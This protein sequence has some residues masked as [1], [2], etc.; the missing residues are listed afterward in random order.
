MIRQP[1][2]RFAFRRIP[3]SR[4]PSTFQWLFA[5]ALL[6]SVIFGAGPVRGGGTNYGDVTFYTDYSEWRDD[7]DG[8][9]DGNYLIPVDTFFTTRENIEKADQSGTSFTSPMPADGQ[10]L[11]GSLLTFRATN[12]GLCGSFTLRALQQPPGSCSNCGLSYDDQDPGGGNSTG[13]NESISIGDID[14]MENDDFE[15]TFPTPS[16]YAMS[17]ALKE[18]SSSEA[19]ES[20]SVYG[21]GG[22][23]L[24]SVPGSAI[25]SSGATGGFVGVI[26]KEP[27]SRVRYDENSGGDDIAIGEFY[28]A[29]AN[30]DPDNDGLSNLAELTA[31]TSLFNGDTDGDGLNDGFELGTG[32]FGEEQ[33]VWDQP[34]FNDGQLVRRNPVFSA[35]VDGDGDLDLVSA[36]TDRVAWYEN[37][38][39]PWDNNNWVEWVI[40]PG[41][42]GQDAFA[43][44]AV[45]MDGDGDMD[46]IAVPHVPNNVSKVGTQNW[47]E[48]NGTPKSVPWTKKT[49][50]SSMPFGNVGDSPFLLATDLDNDGYADLLA[51]GEKGIDVD[52]DL[53]YWYKNAGGIIGNSQQITVNASLRPMSVFAADV[54][55]DG[56]TDVFAGYSEA[57]TGD[58]RWHENDG[59]PGGAGDW[60]EHSIAD[61]QDFGAFSVA[62]L[63]GDGDMDLISA[64]DKSLKWR[65][66][67]GLGIFADSVIL[68]FDIDFTSV[69]G[70]DVDLDGDMDVV[71]AG[72]SGSAWYENGGTPT[73]FFD[74]TKHV[75]EPQ[76]EGLDA[77]I[78]VDLDGDGDLD[79]VSSA[80]AGGL[81]TCSND[82]FDYCKIVAH[83][84]I[85]L[86]NPLLANTDGIGDTDAV[87]DPDAD[88]L[89]NQ[90]EQYLG[91]N[92]LVAD[93]DGDGLLDG[94]EDSNGNGVDPGETDPLNEDTDGDGLLD[95]F[96]VK[97]GFNP[98]VGGEQTQDPD[99]DG[100]DNLEEQTAGT[101]PHDADTDGDG[102]WDGAICGID[103]PAPTC[104]ERCQFPNLDLDPLKPDSDGDGMLDG[105]EVKYRAAG[106]VFNP[107]GS[108]DQ[109]G[110]GIIDGQED[111]DSDGLSN[112]AEQAAG[113]DPTDA[114]TDGDGLTDGTELG[115]GQF[116]PQQ[117]ISDS[118]SG[119]QYVFAADM[120]GDGDMDAL[121]ASYADDKIAWYE[122]DGM[123]TGLGDWTEHVVSTNA[124][125]ATSVFAADVDG[126]GD[127][128]VLS[129]SVNDSK[130]AWY[131]NDG[132]PAVGG[133]TERIISLAAGS[134]TQTV[135]AAD[136]DGDGDMDVLSTSVNPGKVVWYENDGTPAGLGDWK[137]RSIL[138]LSNSISAFAADL[139]RD[140]KLHVLA[141]SSTGGEFIWSTN[142]G[143]PKLGPWPP[144]TLQNDPAGGY[145]SVYAV[146]VDGDGR[147]DAL[148]ALQDTNTIGW[149]RNT[150]A[151]FSPYPVF[152][153]QRQVI[154]NSSLADVRGGALVAKDLDGDGDMDVLSASFSN[155]TI[156][157]HEQGPAGNW[158]EHTISNLTS[159]PLSVF[160][161]D[162]DGDGDRDALSASYDG[163]IAWYQQT[164]LADP[165]NHD[166]DGDGLLDGFEDPDGD[167][168]NNL[169]EQ[170][171]GTDP[172][173][174]DTDND[175]IPDGLDL[176]PDRDPLMADWAISAGGFHSC[177]LYESGVQCWG[178]N[179]HGQS[180]V[181]GLNN[182][183]AVSA[184]Y[185]HSC[186]LDDSGVVCWGDNNSGQSSP[187]PVLTN[188]VAVSAGLDHS[189]A[190]D[191]SGVVCWGNNVY[192]EAT[193]PILAFDK[194]RDGLPDGIEDSNGNG[195]V[196]AGETDPLNEDSDGDGLLDGAEDSNGNGIVDAGETDP[197]SSNRG[198]LAP[199][200]EPDGIIDTGDYLVLVRLVLQ[201]ITATDTEI[202][203]GDL[204]DN[205]SLDSGDVV[206]L[207]RV[208]Q[209]QIPMP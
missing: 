165:L 69:R 44:A 189:C 205:G 73:D 166:T 109:N 49:I 13:F 85:N 77:A 33:R 21:A 94:E 48:N 86:G 37:D 76:V 148:S 46:V 53:L 140:G 149:Y 128:D 209:G 180:T 119:A 183:V 17:F 110:N 67:N 104:C 78:T 171:A 207:M 39:T 80:D 99:A 11:M 84:Q 144:A 111:F 194:D 156:V 164:N 61:F 200:S 24:G 68:D 52:S 25:P 174:A 175:T 83:R 116:G 130:I 204:N 108:F 160:A 147:L 9:D 32:T 138:S 114:D 125:G 72:A 51:R 137:E 179:G 141:G 206:L 42:I 31:G 124:L 113:T 43:V 3:V 23:L 181:P 16:F 79:V 40:S 203:L 187:V 186:A 197:L 59:T 96:E 182:P 81:F 30:E 15:F 102:L 131:E 161:A 34:V 70:A 55:N 132:T 162:L 20:L 133:W 123:P 103:P 157:W 155:G 146:D 168:L 112:A 184:G 202:L 2:H 178:D 192:G 60:I 27:L 74:W 65:A 26:A 71:A 154:S 95:G 62:D 56:D 118:A 152:D 87:D 92:P 41:G 199:R 22:R 75:I 143:S 145:V 169:G 6:T 91:T 82:P 101:N 121:S 89:T 28:F 196:D 38:G 14:D 35:D 151:S 177:A 64:E 153:E 127:T 201:S 19:G 7:V 120:D 167:G 142:D 172:F 8:L 98:V 12:T 191:D 185:T 1:A 158:S 105:F 129:A 50:P 63:D 170:A 117:L 66:N 88:Q 126:D 159:Y 134:Q 176:P 29:C 188:P 10:V 58:I 57:G 45:D 54:D 190:L 106:S 198:D 18:S 208:I 107:S 173:D 100:L 47:Y 163:K 93:T 5:L 122:N 136:V 115:T 139:N 4:Q 193:V 195:I 90:V 135:F 97:N 150:A 36:Q